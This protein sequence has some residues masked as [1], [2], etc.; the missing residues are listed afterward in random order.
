MIL[1][2]WSL[3]I[4]KTKWNIRWRTIYAWASAD[5]FS[6]GDKNLFLPKKQRKRY[7]FSHF[8][9]FKHTIFGR[10]EPP[11]PP[12]RTPMNIRYL[13]Y[14]NTTTVLISAIKTWVPAT[15]KWTRTQ[16]L[17]HNHRS[18]FYYCNYECLLNDSNLFLSL[19]D[20]TKVHKLQY[21]SWV[22]NKLYMFFN[23]KPI[24]AKCCLLK[25]WS[26][27]TQIWSVLTWLCLNHWFT[28]WNQSINPK[29]Y[30]R[31]PQGLEDVSKYP[32]LFAA[33]LDDPEVD[34]TAEDLEKLASRNLIRVF[35]EVEGVRDA[36]K[37]EVPY[38]EWIP[39][40]DLKNNTNCNSNN[41]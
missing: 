6:R 17:K 12:L 34:W 15:K 11:C 31:P 35:K 4:R 32:E 3:A 8:Q 37:Y 2:L 19:F 39:R 20:V 28:K 14:Q 27:V 18:R 29:T 5:F 10:Q 25:K 36:L 38:Q 41:Y 30:F 23:F 26:K 21:K 40:A 9:V 1:F 7:Y 33:L 13:M 22:L 24:F 16:L